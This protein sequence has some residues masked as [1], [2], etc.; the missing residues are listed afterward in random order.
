MSTRRLGRGRAVALVA[1]LGLALF[2]LTLPTWAT[3]VASTTVGAQQ[4]VVAGT[5]AAPAAASAALVVLV[6]G[7]V[8]ALSG[9]V[10]RVLAVA[11]VVVGGTLG[12]VSAA[13]FLADP[14]PVLEQAAAAVSGVPEISGDPQLTA[15]PVLALVVAGVTTLVGLALPFVAG[16]WQRV[17]RRY[18]VGASAPAGPADPRTQA[19]DDWDALTRG[20]DPSTP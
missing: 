14:Q 17:G 4:V 15:F 3:A 6:A 13:G 1:L 18:E 20:D 10:T 2:G 19:R 11:G 12:V 9:R 16:S 8:L 5:D 7:L